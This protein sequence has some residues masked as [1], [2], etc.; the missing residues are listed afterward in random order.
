M[1]AAT[2]KALPVAA[3]TPITETGMRGFLL[4][5]AREQPAL[6]AKIAPQLP[7][8]V[9]K[10]FS[11]YNQTQRRLG[12]LYRGK[13]YAHRVGLEGFADYFTDYTSTPS[14]D[15]SSPA[16]SID[17]SS[18][19]NATPV[20][21][22]TIDTGP[23]P[24]FN[25][26]TGTFSMPAASP[27]ATAA[28]TG[29]AGTPTAQAIGQVIGAASQVFLTNQQAALQQSVLN[30][31]L[32]RAAAGLPP[33]NTSLNQLGVPTISTSGSLSTGALLL[34]GLAAGAAI[35]LSGKKS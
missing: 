21:V 14:I 5:F 33:L 7:G 22:G 32:Q 15:L 24:V 35:L 9:P 12:E 26:S 20:D 2:V 13:M 27:V 18:D 3:K 28:N 34:L 8:A 10:A 11:N 19:I 16:V 31:Q 29:V 17:L 25:A 4:W 30:T 6:Y 23:Q 1:P